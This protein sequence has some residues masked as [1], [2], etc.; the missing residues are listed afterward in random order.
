M[1]FSYALPDC[2]EWFPVVFENLHWIEDV[3]AESSI[4]SRAASMIRRQ[5]K[6]HNVK[7]RV[8]DL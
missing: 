1:V 4:S 5:V 6:Q 8:S 3:V 7:F 2:S